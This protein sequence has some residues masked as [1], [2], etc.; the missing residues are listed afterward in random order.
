LS[1]RFP[2]VMVLFQGGKKGLMRVRR[3]SGENNDKAFVSSSLL[4]L[5][6]LDVLASHKVLSLSHRTRHSDSVSKCTNSTKAP[7]LRL[8]P[9]TYSKFHPLKEYSLSFTTHSKRFHPLYLRHLQQRP[10]NFILY[11]S[12]FV[13]S[14]TTIIRKFLIYIYPH[15]FN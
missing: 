7:D 14:P 9:A 8:S 12:S 15:I 4:R 11:I 13:F 10:L 5:F 3:A 2:K 1:R 6:V